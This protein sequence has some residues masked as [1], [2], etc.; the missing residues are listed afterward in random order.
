[1]ATLRG[2]SSPG[3]FALGDGDRKRLRERLEQAVRRARRARGGGDGVL[4]ALT[5]AV[6]HDVDPSAVVFASR[7]PGEP[8]FCMEQPERE[9]S[10]VAALGCTVAVEARGRDRF[11]QVAAR[12]RALAAVALSDPAD[13]RAAGLIAA[14]GFAFADDGGTSPHWDGFAPAS[15]HVPEVSLA[16]TGDDVRLTVCALVGADDVADDVLARIE[17]RLGTLRRAPLPLLDPDPVGRYHVAASAPP[18]HYEAAVARAVE[19]IRAGELEKIVLAREVQV[20]APAAHDAAAVFGVLRE[21]FAS[22]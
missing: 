1:M 12:W 3:A 20:H 16:R 2:A 14:G 7:Q 21:G 6:G 10:A 19:R 18:E 9:R 22:C 17:R 11:A 15:L 13:A 8:W 4:A 5:V